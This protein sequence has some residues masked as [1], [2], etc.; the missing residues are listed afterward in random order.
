MGYTCQKVGAKQE[1]NEDQ[2]N[3][4]LNISNR[5]GVLWLNTDQTI[6]YQKIYNGQWFKLVYRRLS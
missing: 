6:F 4:V 5:A 1:F 2:K 3:R